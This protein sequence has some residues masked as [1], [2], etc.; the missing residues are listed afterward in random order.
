MGLFNTGKER[1]FIQ[2]VGWALMV[3]MT[4]WSV[5]LHVGE[6]L[7]VVRLQWCFVS[8]GYSFT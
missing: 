1:Y 5:I 2:G 8:Y 7:C 6:V 4:L 3:I